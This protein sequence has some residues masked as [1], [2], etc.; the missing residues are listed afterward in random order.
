MEVDGR[1]ERY[2]TSLGETRSTVTKNFVRSAR[3]YERERR[4]AGDVD[5]SW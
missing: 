5:Q 2:P 4:N 1:E 3:D